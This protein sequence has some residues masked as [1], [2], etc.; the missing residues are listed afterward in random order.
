M[1]CDLV[2][3]LDHRKSKIN[4]DELIGRLVGTAYSQSLD[5]PHVPKWS[6]RSAD[7]TECEIVA[8]D[9]RCEIKVGSR[10]AVVSMDLGVLEFVSNQEL[11]SR[12]VELVDELA[13]YLHSTSA[14]F[15]PD[16]VC[17]FQD[18]RESV[19][20]ERM[21]VEELAAMVIQSGKQALTPSKMGEFH[22]PSG[23]YFE[24]K[25]AF[26]KSYRID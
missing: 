15:L 4:A 3:L 8:A 18:M 24:C 11:Q 25:K 5:F 20:Q 10:T 26:T 16:D 13:K 19:L 2:I 17:P 14:V 22:R 9:G 12:L 21:S 7:E 6:V 23:I 1:G